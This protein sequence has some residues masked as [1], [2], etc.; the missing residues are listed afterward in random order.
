MDKLSEKITEVQ[1]KIGYTFRNTHLL[2]QAFTR[3]SFSNEF[4]GQNNEVLEFIGDETLDFIV[5]KAICDTYGF[6]QE[7][8]PFYNEN[9]DFNDFTIKAHKNEK[10]FTEIKKEIVCNEHLAKIIRKFGFQN[11]LYLG[12]TDKNTN[13]KNQVKVQAD[14][15]EAIVGAMTID[16][17]WDLDKIADPVLKLLNLDNY[18]DEIDDGS[19]EYPAKCQ[20]DTAINSLKELFEHGYISEP[21]Y[22]IDD[23]QVNVDE[24]R[25]WKCTCY[26]KSH[27]ILK[28]WLA[29]NKKLAKRCAAYATLCEFYDVDPVE[30]HEDY[31]DEEEDDE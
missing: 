10:D 25:W 24:K 6:M 5:T 26:I 14:L 7:E 21:I 19:N 30:L 16:C 28:S 29:I 4:G 2:Q 12:K 27:D 8:S 13:V 11:Y 9:E 15:F 17:D 31:Y 22:Q 23:E 20:L 1:M 18:L 3:S